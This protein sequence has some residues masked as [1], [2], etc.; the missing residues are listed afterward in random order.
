VFGIESNKNVEFSNV[1]T[2]EDGKYVEIGSL[3]G[4]ENGKYVELMGGGS[5][6]YIVKCSQDAPDSGT[7]HAPRD[8]IFRFDASSDNAQVQL[9]QSTNYGY[10]L[11]QPV[12]GNGR[13]LLPAYISAENAQYA[14]K[15]RGYYYST[16]NGKTWTFVE[17]ASLCSS[18]NVA[19]FSDGLFRRPNNSGK[20]YTSSDAVNWIDTG[21]SSTIPFQYI[22]VLKNTIVALYMPSNAEG[23]TTLYYSKDNGNGWTSVNYSV[24]RTKLIALNSDAS[25][26]SWFIVIKSNSNSNSYYFDYDLYTVIN[27]VPA[28]NG[29][30]IDYISLSSSAYAY[31]AYDGNKKCIVGAGKY[32]RVVEYGTGWTRAD[33]ATVTNV[34]LPIQ[35][36]DMAYMD[37]RFI[38]F[39]R[40]YVGYAYS[41]DGISWTTASYTLGVD[42]TSMYVL[43]NSQ[44]L[45]IQQ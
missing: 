5:C 13:V 9:R 26:N 16:N 28:A 8:G 29:H 15:S 10:T 17:N 36:Y 11:G 41:T 12:Y 42:G 39:G 4:V 44:P 22:L 33:G 31:A 3:F 45:I 25:G 34:T 35:A 21:K 6:I 37:G 27:G 24:G 40:D 1:F 20:I 18:Y 14:S 32:I 43:H 23:S 38:A 7:S 19:W 30:I 2:V